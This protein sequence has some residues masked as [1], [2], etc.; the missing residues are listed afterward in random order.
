MLRHL[1]RPFVRASSSSWL[2]SSLSTNTATACR[3]VLQSIPSSS[4]RMFSLSTHCNPLLRSSTRP[5]S[6]FSNPLLMSLVRQKSDDIKAVVLRNRVK[7]ASK[8]KGKKYKLKNNRAAV[9]RWLVMGAGTFK[10]AQAGMR[11]LNRKIDGGRRNRS[12]GGL[13]LR[14]RSQSC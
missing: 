5:T 14:R 6:I 12:G 4:T 11:H 10:R 13:L 3:Q 1:L 8:R 9:S 7:V 2:P